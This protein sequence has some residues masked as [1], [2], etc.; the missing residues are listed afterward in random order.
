MG[1]HLHWLALRPEGGEN[2]KNKKCRE[3]KNGDGAT[4]H[5]DSPG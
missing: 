2:S 4:T 1:L 3:R 5:D